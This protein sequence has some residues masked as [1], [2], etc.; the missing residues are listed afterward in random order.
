MNWGSKFL[1]QKSL[2]ARTVQE[3]V[4]KSKVF[5]QIMVRA[6]SATATNWASLEYCKLIA[7][8]AQ[9]MLQML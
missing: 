9:S 3:I 2:L 6:H 7:W 4:I 1:D 5:A 8:A